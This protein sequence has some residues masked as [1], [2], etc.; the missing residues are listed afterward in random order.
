MAASAA[1]GLESNNLTIGAGAT[2]LANGSFNTSRSTILGGAGGGVGGTFE[3]AAN[4]TLDYTSSSVIS[5]TGS[6]IKTGAGTLSLGGVD[7]YTG[8]TY[9]KEGTLVSTS[10]QA[11]GPQPPA[12]SNLYAHHIYDG[13]TL[14]IAVGSWSTERQIELM[15]DTPS[16]TDAARIDITNGFTQQRNGLIHGTGKLDLVGT[17]T[18]I[19]TNAN[20]YSGGTIVENGMLQVN[21]NY[22]PGSGDIDTPEHLAA[23]R[24]AHLEERR[25]QS[26]NH[27]A[28][29]ASAPGTH[30]AADV[31]AQ[32]ERQRGRCYWCSTKVGEAYHVD[33]VIP[34]SKGGGNGPENLVIACPACNQKKHAK[35]PMDFAGILC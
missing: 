28:R 5:G 35:H 18:M 7:T 2:L 20:T 30:T 31:A 26:H 32:Y 11:P 4:I 33:H 1:L 24:A 29:V 16:T 22:A 10:G 17:G 8:G 19:V 25:V 15:G 23:Y 3:V 21:N 6:L 14:Q 34:L 12:G 9:I 13:A 27:R